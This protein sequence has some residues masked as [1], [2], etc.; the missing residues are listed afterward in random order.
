LAVGMDGGSFRCRVKGEDVTWPGAVMLAADE[1]LSIRP[2][3]SGNYGY[4]RFSAELDLPFVLGSV[5]TS[6]RV[7]LGGVEGRAL[8]RG[9][10]LAFKKPAKGAPVHLAP[11]IEDPDDPI[12][13][14]WGLHADSFAPAL[15]QR[16]LDARFR[17]SPQLDR[18]GVRLVDGSGIFAG[19]GGLSLVSDAII[20]GD[21]QILGDGTPIVLM[22][23]HQPTG[24]YPR[25]ATIISADLD[26]FAQL[27]PGTEIRFTS[28]TLERAHGLSRA[29]HGA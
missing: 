24:G 26:R 25:I 10:E 2:G 12:R 13:V 11:T 1:T 5:S 19:S 18:M 15:R 9:D 20:A 23:D 29:R 28:I 27:R 4:L 7:G 8:R 14:M 22:R 6:S 21:V 17:V 3:P 16:F